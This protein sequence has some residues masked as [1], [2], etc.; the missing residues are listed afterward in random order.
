MVKPTP[1]VQEQLRQAVR[2]TGQSL[3]RLAADAG[4]DS[5]RLSRFMRGERDLTFAAA[6]KLCECLGL[7]LVG[8]EDACP[9]P[10]PEQSP[11][12]RGKKK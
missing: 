9:E 3:N 6:A 4:L 10:A 5:G 8:G 12:R 1:D 2:A 7:K 11:K